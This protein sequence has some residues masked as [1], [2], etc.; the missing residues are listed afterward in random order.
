MS[1]APRFL[2]LVREVGKEARWAWL[3]LGNGVSILEFQSGR[4]M[5]AVMV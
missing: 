5:G 3:R 1:F 4:W 2:M